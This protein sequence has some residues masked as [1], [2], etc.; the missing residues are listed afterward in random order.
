MVRR[1]PGRRRETGW[2][3]GGSV[4][5][6][7]TRRVA[8]GAVAVLGGFGLA[9]APPVSAAPSGAAQSLR[10]AALPAGCAA[11]QARVTCTYGY[12]GVEQEFTVP[13][14][15]M[16]V[17]VMAT[18]APGASVPEAEGTI[19]GGLG[20]TATVTLAVVPGSDLYVEVGGPG[21]TGFIGRGWNGGGPAGGSFG[22][23]G[24]G[25][26]D[27]RTV[28][29]GD[30]CTS[31]NSASLASRLVVAGG[32]GGAGGVGFEDNGSLALGGDGGSGGSSG[33]AGAA[34][35]IGSGGQG[36][37]PGLLTGGGAGG[38][39]GF[40]DIGNAVN[41]TAGT[42][43]SLAQ[44]GTGGATGTTSGGGGGGGGFY[45]GG[46]GGGGADTVGQPSYGTGSGGGAGGSSYAP[47]G[48]IGVAVT[49]TPSVVISYAEPDLTMSK[50]ANID[51]DATS[52]ATGKVV[53]YPLP[54]V[55]DPSQ[56]PPPSPACEPAS[57]STFPIGTTTVTCTVSDP[58]D[59]N[60]P[61]SVSFSVVVN[62]ALGVVTRSLPPAVAHV[63]YQETLKASG[64]AAPYAWALAPGSMAL[65]RGLSLSSSGVISGKPVAKGTAKVTVQVRDAA[66]GPSTATRSLTI[67]VAAPDL[68]L[69]IRQ[70][71]IFYH[72]H[73]GTI[74]AKVGDGGTATAGPVWLVT[75]L[76]A[77]LRPIAA[78]GTGW[79][80]RRR[81]DTLSCEHRARLSAGHSSVLTVRVHVGAGK[82]SK[83]V[84]SATSTATGA[85]SRASIRIRIR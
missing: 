49:A 16:N 82:G 24:G 29:C 11:A 64:G 74:V 32:G 45:G 17:K 30:A 42:T 78:S 60:S 65:P 34:D 72:G 44:G 85:V 15:V 81:G 40:A 8:A 27:V 84:V 80:C 57:G 55:T 38:T 51:V 36:G 1:W 70:S 28:S 25:A 83:V 58:Q 3:L 7:T 50:P 61:L 14:G 41:G 63:R 73:T 5:L 67:W 47:G 75:R 26:S 39:G 12:T 66:T 19:P 35:D 9:T 6:L 54:V 53:T 43:G 48:T 77:G 62:P 79:S 4:A 76:P 46:G 59:G 68:R 10:S 21:T 18:G 37:G 56:A 71:G 22:G 2:R 20:G 69:N 52:G 13:A 23:S 31:S 33:A